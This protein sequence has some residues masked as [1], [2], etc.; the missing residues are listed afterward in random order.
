MEAFYSAADSAMG[1]ILQHVGRWERSSHNLVDGK[2]TISIGRR[3]G[4]VGLLDWFCCAGWL[5]HTRLC[6]CKRF[7]SGHHVTGRLRCSDH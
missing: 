3:S 2:D 6:A 1:R 4:C 7:R 5:V